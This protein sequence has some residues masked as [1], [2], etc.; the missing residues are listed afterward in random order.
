MLSL[1]EEKCGLIHVLC[2]SDIETTGFMPVNYYWDNP[3]QTFLYIYASCAIYVP[4][5]T[6]I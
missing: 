1:S 4:G 2:Q 5:K 3:S 6:I